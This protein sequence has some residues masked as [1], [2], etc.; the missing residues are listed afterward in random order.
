VLTV[1]GLQPLRSEWD[2]VIDLLVMSGMFEGLHDPLSGIVLVPVAAALTPAAV[3]Y[4][5]MAAFTG[6]SAMLLVLL[7]SRSTCFPRLYLVCMALFAGFVIASVRAV[8]GLM[9]AVEAFQE[10]MQGTNA[11]PEEIAQVR[12]VIGQHV[13][14]VSS[15]AEIL[16]WI[17][18]G[19]LVWLPV[20][21]TSRRVY[22]TFAS[23][24]S[25]AQA[26]Q[27]PPISRP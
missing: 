17:V 23:R 20:L 19:Y 26:L 10:L 18:C 11:R 13:G 16:L 21:F 2:R 25:T 15:A 1:I 24:V 8:A 3:E 12:E 5:A 14:I 7:L 27:E 4:A 22:T 6:A 9:L